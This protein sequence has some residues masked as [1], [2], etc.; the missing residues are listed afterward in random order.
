[1]NVAA[2]VQAIQHV[3]IMALPSK[4]KTEFTTAAYSVSHSPDATR[5]ESSCLGVMCKLLWYFLYQDSHSAGT[6]KV[7]SEGCSVMICPDRVA[8]SVDVES[9]CPCVALIIPE[10]VGC[11]IRIRLGPPSQGLA[12]P[13]GQPGN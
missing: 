6:A 5:T 3:P 10:W 2:L 7:A 9:V 11:A 1:V 13:I 12:I 8:R 4:G